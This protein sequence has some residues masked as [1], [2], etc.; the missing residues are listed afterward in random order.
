MA[1][2]SSLFTPAVDES[3]LMDDAIRNLLAAF[4]GPTGDPY[5]QMT[6]SGQTPPDYGVDWN[7]FEANENTDLSLSSEQEAVGLIAQGLLERLDQLSDEDLSEDEV[8]ERSDDEGEELLEP[9]VGGIILD[10]HYQFLSKY[11]RRFAR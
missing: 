6:K 4:S 9:V 1:G 8:V 10:G 11:L 7:L 2:P 5:P 3:G